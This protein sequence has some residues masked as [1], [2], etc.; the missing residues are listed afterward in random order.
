MSAESSEM[1][2]NHIDRLEAKLAQRD[3]LIKEL[4]EC[5]VCDAAIKSLKEAVDRAENQR[6][7]LIL[8]IRDID[9]WIKNWNT[10]FTEDDEWAETQAKIDLALL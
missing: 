1:L 8:L 9:G 5:P 6:D 3:K 7:S 10:P 2:R 4:K